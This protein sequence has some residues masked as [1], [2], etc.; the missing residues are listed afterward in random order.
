[1]E[2]T[3]TD[4]DALSRTFRV[5]IPAAQLQA[6]LN[7]KIE[8]V[9]PRVNLK[10]FRPGNV[11]ASHIKKIYGDG[12]LREIIDEE[13]QKS[14]EEAIK[15]ADVRI[16]SE[17]HLHLESDLDKVAGGQEDLAFHFHVDLMPEFEPADPAALTLERPTAAV[18][19]E[20]VE[21]ALKNIAEAN[22]EFADKDG[23]AATG[24]AVT[25][26]FL[27]K[28]GGEAFEG[29]AA[30]GA[31]LTLGSGQFIPGFEDQLIGVKA[32]DEKQI[33]VTFP[34]D[35]PAEELKG[36]AATFDVKV[37]GVKAPQEA[38]LD[39]EFAKRLG[40]SNIDE[41]REALRR[42][43]ESDH[44]AQ[45]RAKAKRKLF[46]ALDARHSFDLP[47]GM[48][49][50]EFGQ[51][52][53]QLEADREAGRLDPEDAA[54]S[55]EDLEKEYRAIAE[56]R[57]RL[58]LILA[59]IGRRNDIQVSEQEVAQ[60][61]GEQARRF[62]GQERQVVEFYQKNPQAL[63]QIRAPLYEEKVVDFILEL[64]KVTNIEVSKE[65]LFADDEA[66]AAA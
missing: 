16:A 39:D 51:I 43:L 27:G 66:P 53:R 5:V 62:P 40:L 22:R 52:W 54:K 4:S 35:Y 63:A 13:V 31:S 30:E 9:R 26:D 38:K 44:A 33:D 17:P 23:A 56:R 28:I 11:P 24:D 47:K 15:Q 57:V 19:D 34:E 29:G 2:C 45:S 41:V 46:D 64:A 42:R 10:G 1:M 20:D 50:F 55:Q 61:V 18:S 32:G 48:V 25:I 65:D 58:G 60:A 14:T 6:Q 49:D 37:H 36:K 12:M 3:I 59:E 8:E 21:A 7:A